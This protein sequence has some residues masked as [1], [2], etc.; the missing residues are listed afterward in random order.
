MLKVTNLVDREF[1]K[2]YEFDVLA[3]NTNSAEELQSSAKVRVL[4][5]DVDDMAPV[6]LNTTIYF[7]PGDLTSQAVHF[8]DPDQISTSQISASFAD[9]QNDDTAAESIRKFQITTTGKFV[10]T[11]IEVYQRNG[12]ITFELRINHAVIV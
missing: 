12:N 3:K 9:V 4:I 5:K 11:T 1:K 10:G 2:Q 7:C 6:P 8:K